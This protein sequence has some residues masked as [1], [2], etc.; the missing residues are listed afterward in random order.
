[1]ELTNTYKFN[2]PSYD[3]LVDIAQLNVNMDAIDKWLSILAAELLTK[4]NEQDGVLVG[5]PV[6]TNI[7]NDLLSR[8]VTYHY[9]NSRINVKGVIPC[10]STDDLPDEGEEGYIY[11]C[12]DGNTYSE[13]IW[14]Y[15]EGAYKYIDYDVYLNK[16][17]GELKKND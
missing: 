10:E 1:M 6:A 13:Y 4:V 2:K 3:D 17:N 7:H 14:G 15:S 8:L 16:Q 5:K 9:L 11:L 12:K